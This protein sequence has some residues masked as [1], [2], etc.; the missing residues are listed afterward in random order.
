VVPPASNAPLTLI[1]ED[2]RVRFQEA[3]K[4]FAAA[5]RRECETAGLPRIDLR[6]VTERGGRVQGQLY[7]DT[8]HLWPE[9][10]QQAF[11]MAAP[12][13]GTA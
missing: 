13:E 9:A 12:S 10:W 8:N 11:A 1:G 4:R 3:H 5:L 2:K 6:A 7:V